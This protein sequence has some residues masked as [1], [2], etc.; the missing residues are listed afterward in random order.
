[1]PECSCVH[2]VRACRR[3]PGVFHPVE[4]LRAVRAGLASDLMLAPTYE[5]VTRQMITALMPVSLSF[6]TDVNRAAVNHRS[7]QDHAAGPCTFLNADERCE[8]HDTGFKPMECR[9]AVLCGP[10]ED[11]GDRERLAWLTPVGRHVI[12]IWKRELA[13]ATEAA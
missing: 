2:C 6:Y 8:I 11:P 5:Q 4:A 9:K 3:I 7:C 12:N 1:M 10:K 13:R